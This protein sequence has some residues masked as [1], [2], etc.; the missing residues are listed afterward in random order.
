MISHVNYR[1]DTCIH[2]N[3]RHDTCIH[4]NYRHGTWIHINYRHGTWIHVNYRHDTWI[5]VIKKVFSQMAISVYDSYFCFVWC[6]N[7]IWKMVLNLP[8]MNALD[9]VIKPRIN[10]AAVRLTWNY[11]YTTCSRQCAH[12]HVRI[13]TPTSM[14]YARNTA[15]P[16]HNAAVEQLRN[17]NIRSA[18]G[19]EFNSLCGT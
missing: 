15:K 8:F 7:L 13:L 17:E 19:K 16:S 12:V 9:E 6:N 4:V 10:G 1:H 11:Y 14:R 3:F 2:V 18:V 5:H